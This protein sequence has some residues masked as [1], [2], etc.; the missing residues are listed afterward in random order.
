MPGAGSGPALR[1]HADHT[2]AAERLVLEPPAVR[3]PCHGATGFR[4]S[5]HPTARLSVADSNVGSCP[6]REHRA[7]EPATPTPHPLTRGAGLPLRGQ[8]RKR[9]PWAKAL[10]PAVQACALHATPP[11]LKGVP[12]SPQTVLRAVAAGCGCAITEAGRGRPLADTATPVC[13]LWG[14]RAQTRA[15][16]VSRA[17]VQAWRVSRARPEAEAARAGVWPAPHQGPC[18]QGSWRQGPSVNVPAPGRS[19]SPTCHAQ[20]PPWNCRHEHEATKRLTRDGPS[21]KDGGAQVR[22]AALIKL[23][24]GRNIFEYK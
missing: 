5:S 6:S 9:Q 7:P 2:V 15:W 13:R 4:A 24:R 11:V 20:R 14:M 19:R 21:P 3:P 18:G 16:R 10:L 17:E 8:P 12:R 1:P 23:Q 22:P